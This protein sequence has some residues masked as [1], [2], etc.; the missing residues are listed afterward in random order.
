MSPRVSIVKFALVSMIL[1]A[2]GLT[3]AIAQDNAVNTV[4]VDLNI[5]F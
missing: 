2:L 4:Q 5:K 1:A 3:P